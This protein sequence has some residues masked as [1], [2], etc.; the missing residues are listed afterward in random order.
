MGKKEESKAGK[1]ECCLG[2][3]NGSVGLKT[4]YQSTREDQPLM[5]AENKV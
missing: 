5:W 1:H 2:T 3:M 4:K